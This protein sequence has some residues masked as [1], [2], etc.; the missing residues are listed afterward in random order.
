MKFRKW[1]ENW[2]ITGLKIKTP[3]L[4]MD[5]SP[6]D[7][8]KDAAWDMYIELLTRIATQPL[9]DEDGIEQTA[10]ESI[11]KLFDLTRNIIKAHGR[12]CE[13]FARIAIIILNQIIRPFT[14][15][16]HKLSSEGAFQNEAQ[17]KQYRKELKELQEKLIKYSKMLAEISGVEDLTKME[18]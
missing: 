9:S 15:R 12:S 8:D 10:L 4:E 5:W 6:Q 2:D 18:E 3:I 11:F 13:G 16:W 7:S 1:F 17:C 14:A